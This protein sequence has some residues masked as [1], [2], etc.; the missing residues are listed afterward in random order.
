MPVVQDK[1]GCRGWE[2]GGKEGL[3]GRGRVGRR[4]Q[5]GLKGMG[6]VGRLGQG[7]LKGRGRVGRGVRVG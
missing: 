1:G 5:G 2:R 6:R 3:K 7:G 4:G